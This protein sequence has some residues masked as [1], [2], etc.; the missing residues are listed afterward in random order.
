MLLLIL[1]ACKTGTSD[2]V[3]NVSYLVNH[4]LCKMLLAK[5]KFLYH[6][7]FYQLSKFFLNFY[8]PSRMILGVF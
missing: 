8:I 5:A 1:A 4:C 3:L 2:Y 6:V 7:T